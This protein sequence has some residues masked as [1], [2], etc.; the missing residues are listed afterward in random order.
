MP[1]SGQKKLRWSLL[2][3]GLGLNR[4]HEE[5]EEKEEEGKKEGEA[6]MG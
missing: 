1:T 6:S 2:F 3:V 4:H 5:E